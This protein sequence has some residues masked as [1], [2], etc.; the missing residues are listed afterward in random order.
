MYT[1]GK[2]IQAPP[3][4]R[5]P[6]SCG[7]SWPVLKRSPFV[8]CLLQHLCHVPRLV[9]AHL[10]L[11]RRTHPLQRQRCQRRLELLGSLA[12]QAAS[13]LDSI[14]TVHLLPVLVQRLLAD[15]D[16]SAPPLQYQL[17]KIAKRAPPS[18]SVPISE[19]CQ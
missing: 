5:R 4:P 13:V 2:P 3:L 8:A 12:L 10:Q 7:F 1:E 9:R 6:S 17:C 15:G 18:G 16:V 14:A 19:L 11:R